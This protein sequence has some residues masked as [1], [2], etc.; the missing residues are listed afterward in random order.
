M[1]K[2][3]KCKVCGQQ[4]ASS[5]KTC[6]HCGAKVKKSG[7]K[8]FFI[9]LLL[10]TGICL[11][12]VSIATSST[13]DKAVT[14]A[15]DKVNSDLVTLE[16]FN[17]INSS[18]SYDDVCK[19]FGKGG[20]LDSEVDLAGIKTQIYHWYDITGIANCNVTFQNGMMTAKAQIGLK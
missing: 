7:A 6:P 16:N 8:M 11:I 15:A 2:L 5:A 18:M 13:V 12:A 10:I 3:I 20:T 9:S 19:L 1:A 14:T 17:K 4:I